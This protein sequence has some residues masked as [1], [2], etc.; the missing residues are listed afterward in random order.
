M[1]IVRGYVMLARKIQNGWIAHAAPVAREIWI[2]LFRNANYT[3][4]R[5]NGFTIKR[6]QL[7]CKTEQIQEELSWYVGYRKKRYSRRQCEGSMKVLAKERMIERTK[8][9]GGTLVTILN[10]DKYQDPK[11]YENT[12][13]GTDETSHEEALPVHPYTKKEKKEKKKEENTPLYIP[14]KGETHDEK[15]IRLLKGRDDLNLD[16]DDIKIFMPLWNRWLA[17]KKQE[18]KGSYKAVET[19]VSAA[20]RFMKLANFEQDSLEEILEYSISCHC[21]GLF[22]P[23]PDQRVKQ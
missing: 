22:K 17:Y 10:Y 15:F 5:V 19:E 1:G 16:D 12:L 20:V 4:K 11:N 3:D 14:P 7:L 6:G 8:V 13:E 9:P 18:K 21:Q 2:W 23:R